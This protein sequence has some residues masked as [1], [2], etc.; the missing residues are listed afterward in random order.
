ME[1]LILLGMFAG[2]ALIPVARAE[3]LEPPGWEEG[4][5][6]PAGRR[7]L[8]DAAAEPPSRAGAPAAEK[9]GKGKGPEP[10]S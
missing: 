7:I 9:G 5:R 6:A 10:V 4:R 3:L 1:R 2:V 8:Q